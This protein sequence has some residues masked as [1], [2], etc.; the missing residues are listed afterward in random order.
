[1]W[2]FSYKLFKSLHLRAI[3][4]R[5]KGRLVFFF[6]NTLDKL[7]YH[8]LCKISKSDAGNVILFQIKAFGRNVKD[9]V[10]ARYFKKV[11]ARPIFTRLRVIRQINR[12]H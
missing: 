11:T 8:Q 3:N 2:L 6:E 12:I 10:L 4:W 7:I 5:E 9:T 1:M